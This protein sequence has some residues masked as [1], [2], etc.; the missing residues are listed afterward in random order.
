LPGAVDNPYPNLALA[1]ACVLSSRFEGLPNIVLEAM[2][3][4]VPVVATDCPSGLREV[5][6][7]GVT[8]LLTPVDD[9]PA[10]AGAL[11][12][13]FNDRALRERCV[14]GAFSN[15]ALN[16]RLDDTVRRYEELLS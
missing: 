8:G 6:E 16:F 3:C 7:A 10:L 13:L 14:E 4:R 5:V 11:H 1:E 15:V 2:A 9:A 12:A